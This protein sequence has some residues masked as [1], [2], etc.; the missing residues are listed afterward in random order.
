M[1]RCEV[2]GG[3]CGTAV[4]TAA[5]ALLSLHEHVCSVIC[6]VSM[7]NPISQHR[8]HTLGMILCPFD[9]ALVHGGGR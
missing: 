7:V 4:D 3:I 5:P 9:I 1:K 2:C 8:L 6:C